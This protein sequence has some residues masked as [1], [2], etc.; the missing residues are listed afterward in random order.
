MSTDS[1]LSLASTLLLYSPG[2]LKD[3]STES[4][5]G[6]NALQ[7]AKTAAALLQDFATGQKSPLD[8]E[9]SRTGVSSYSDLYAILANAKGLGLV[10]PRAA[11]EPEC[12][13]PLYM[14]SLSDDVQQLKSAV[15][16]PLQWTGH[17]LPTGFV[18]LEDDF[19]PG[20]LL[21]HL[22]FGYGNPSL[23]SQ[24]LELARLFPEKAIAIGR[25]L[26][27]LSLIHISEPTRPY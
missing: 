24:A 2:T 17:A 18:M 8:H 20:A 27:K 14:R 10:R 15:V 5:R 7:G 12:E 9:I 6:Y 1:G 3:I 22:R 16:E 23:E 4:F 19:D 21:Q 13:R 25:V 26:I 11:S